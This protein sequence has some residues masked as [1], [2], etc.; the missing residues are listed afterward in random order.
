MEESVKHV[1]TPAQ[2][3]AF[4]R[5]LRGKGKT[6]FISVGQ[7]APIAGQEGYAFPIIGNVP[8]SHKVAMKF[9]AD[10]YSQVLADKGAMCVIRTLGNCVFIGRAA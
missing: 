6:L 8:V 3:Q 5:K 7:S 1:L 4:V 9:L 10:A 2:A